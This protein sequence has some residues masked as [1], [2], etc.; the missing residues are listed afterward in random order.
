MNSLKHSYAV[1]KWS[2]STRQLDIV[3]KCS[4]EEDNQ[5]ARVKTQDDLEYK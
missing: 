1:G 2:K 4:K 3:Y 5:T